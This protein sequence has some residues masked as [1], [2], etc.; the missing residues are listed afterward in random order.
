M[1]L[2]FLLGLFVQ[3]RFLFKFVPSSNNPCNDW[4][5]RYLIP[6]G[7]ACGLAFKDFVRGIIQEFRHQGFRPRGLYSRTSPLG[8]C[9]QGFCPRDFVQGN[10]NFGPPFSGQNGIR[11]SK[12]KQC[13][14]KYNL[15][16]YYL[17]VI[18]FIGKFY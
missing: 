6:R 5:I 12:T 15:F 16:K 2:G 8:F 7:V 17:E 13:I 10:P 3:V 1:F 18:T 14:F 9:H 11:L 4:T